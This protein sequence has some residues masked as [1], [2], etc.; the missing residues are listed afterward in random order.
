MNTNWKEQA[1]TD[2][3]D[4]WNDPPS[5]GYGV[6]GEIRMSNA[7]SVQ[8]VTSVLIPLLLFVLIRVHSWFNPTN[9]ELRH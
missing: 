7:E 6:A 3:T 1:T 5:L 4:G 9:F 8:S 2:D